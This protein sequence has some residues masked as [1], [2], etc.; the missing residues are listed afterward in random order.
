MTSRHKSYIKRFQRNDLRW[1]GNSEDSD[2]KKLREMEQACIGLILGLVMS[3]RLWLVGIISPAISWQSFLGFSLLS[4]LAYL[5][6][7]YYW[8]HKS[9]N[10]LVGAR[11]HDFREL[12]SWVNLDQRAS[13]STSE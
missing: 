2:L 10:Y 5:I 9:V 13:P 11:I 7:N 8:L 12:P 4:F 3:M 1:R 6:Y